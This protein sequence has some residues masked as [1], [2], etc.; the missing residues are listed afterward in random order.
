MNRDY[1]TGVSNTPVLF[2]G[3]EVEHSIHH[4]KMTLFVVGIRDC[5][6]IVDI[7]QND[8]SIKHIYLA[9]N[10]SYKNRDFDLWATF[11]TDLVAQL[12][13]YAITLESSYLELSTDLIRLCKANSV[14]LMVG[15]AIP[16]YHAG[17]TVK[18]DDIDFKCTN[19]G[20]WCYNPIFKT[21][22][23]TPWD[24]YKQDEIIK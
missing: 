8:E 4:G 23:F 9:A 20:V 5:N 19:P 7:V 15:V 11:V 13:S 16:L 12:S 22:G 6:E 17:I 3:K 24:Q 18:I 14:H 2:K 21:E 10:H 1:S